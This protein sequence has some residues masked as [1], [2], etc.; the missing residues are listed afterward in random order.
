MADSESITSWSDAGSW[1]SEEA[2]ALSPLWPRMEALRKALIERIDLVGVTYTGF[3]RQP[4]SPLVRTV[5]VLGELNSMLDAA[6][7]YFVHFSD[8]KIKTMT[9]SGGGTVLNDVDIDSFSHNYSYT[10]PSG[11]PA[12]ASVGFSNG[13]FSYSETSSEVYF[14]RISRYN[15]ITRSISFKTWTRAEVEAVSG[16]ISIPLMGKE[17][18]ILMRLYKA[19]NLLRIPSGTLNISVME[20]GTFIWREIVGYYQEGLTLYRY[21]VPGADWDDYGA[22]GELTPEELWELCYPVPGYPSGSSVHVMCID[23]FI[24]EPENYNDNYYDIFRTSVELTLQNTSFAFGTQIPLKAS[25]FMITNHYDS[26]SY[27]SEPGPEGSDIKIYEGTMS[28]G[29]NSA[30]IGMGMDNRSSMPSPLM[31]SWYVEK[32]KRKYDMEFQM[33]SDFGLKFF[34]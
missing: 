27:N 4:V 31:S 14:K 6:I 32:L 30:A 19:V 28:A 34:I 29:G 20:S 18:V 10:T 26:T 11:G 3:L 13:L 9:F 17:N 8:G 15:D 23:R 7:P 12:D 21:S 16:V 24:A 25:Y 33:D 2:M 22:Y 5:T 1:D